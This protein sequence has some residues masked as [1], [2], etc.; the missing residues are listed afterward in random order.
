VREARAR[1]TEKGCFAS[2]SFLLCGA[3]RGVTL[4]PLL[5]RAGVLVDSAR[6]S[7]SANER[8]VFERAAARAHRVLAR[9]AL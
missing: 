2:D 6:G 3:P 7:S 4:D 1:T 5:G 9:A 8:W